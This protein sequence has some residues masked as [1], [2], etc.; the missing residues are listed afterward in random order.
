M[1]LAA[2]EMESVKGGGGGGGGTKKKREWIVKAIP[3]S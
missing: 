2:M 3:A 1:T